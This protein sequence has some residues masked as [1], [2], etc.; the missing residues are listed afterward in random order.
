MRDLLAHV[1]T[2]GMIPLAHA[3][4]SRA[5]IL[6]LTWLGSWADVGLYSAAMRFVDLARTIP[7]AYGRALYPVL[8][9]LR[10]AAVEEYRDVTAR[11]VRTGLSM[12]VPITLG[13]FGVGGPLV[14]LLYGPDLAGATT[15][16]QVLA[17]TLL[18]LAIAIVLAQVLFSADRQAIDLRVNVVA[19]L[20]SLVGGLALVPRFGPN[21]AA[22]AT[23]LAGVTYAALQYHWTRAHVVDPKALGAI[24]KIVA[25]AIGS[26]LVI[27]VLAPLNAWIATAVGCACYGA[28]LL[29]LGYVQPDD[30]AR[31]RFMAAS[32][33]GR[34]R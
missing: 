6:L 1:P 29:L 32:A 28:A 27:A 4:Y 25:A 24:G 5:D 3:V 11:G 19:A 18:P 30:L 34:P 9:R 21:G 26:A 22:V 15:S 23:L 20:V 14:T 7:P 8:A 13:L 2:T 10:T 16:L 33:A 12:T 31:V 17:W